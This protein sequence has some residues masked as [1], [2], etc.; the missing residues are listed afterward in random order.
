[1]TRHGR[2][3]RRPRTRSLAKVYDEGW[4][5]AVGAVCPYQSIRGWLWT[6]GAEDRAVERLICEL[7]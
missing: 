1:M 4:D 6:Q 5:A 7:I 3:W 2:P